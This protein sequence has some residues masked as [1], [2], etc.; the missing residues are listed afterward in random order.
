MTYSATHGRKLEAYNVK[1]REAKGNLE[2]ISCGFGTL[3]E[4][5]FV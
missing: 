5:G 2:T 3:R 1:A 4:D